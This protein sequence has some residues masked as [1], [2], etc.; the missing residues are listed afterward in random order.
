MTKRR[1]SSPYPHPPSD[2]VRAVIRDGWRRCDAESLAIVAFCLGHASDRDGLTTLASFATRELRKEPV[3]AGA[4]LRLAP[5]PGVADRAHLL[6]CY[7]PTADRGPLAR[8]ADA[9]GAFEDFAVDDLAD[10]A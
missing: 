1:H 5:I 8:L 10:L 7:A 4:V 9:A 2:Y 6:W 3:L